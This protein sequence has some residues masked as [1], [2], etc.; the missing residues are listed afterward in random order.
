ISRTSIVQYKGKRRL[1][2]EIAQELKVDAIVEG[3]VMRSGDRVRITAQL[4]DARTDRHLWAEAYERDLRDVLALQDDVAKAI[5]RE[6][7][8]TL[9]PP[10]EALLSNAP[11]IDPA[12]HQAYLRGQYELHGATAE[13][14]EILQGRSIEKAIG[15]FQEALTHDPKD[16]L[17]Y[18]GL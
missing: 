1:V 2:P 4:I 3:T 10:E 13:P 6:V 16:A 11:A 8:I 5:A 9:T 18:A 17:A 7:K 15:Y 12:A 14:T